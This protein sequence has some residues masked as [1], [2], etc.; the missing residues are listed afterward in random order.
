MK[1]LI[2]IIIS[3]VVFIYYRYT[4]KINPEFEIIQTQLDKFRP[5]MF[6]EKQPIILT[7]KL[8]DPIQLTKSIFKYLYVF[9]TQFITKHT[10]RNQQVK[11]KYLIVC[12]Q[13]DTTIVTIYHPKGE[14]TKLDINLYQSQCII[15]PMAWK[16]NVSHDATCI[17][18]DDTFTILGKYLI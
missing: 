16:Y 7:D 1:I 8:V 12:S 13:S 17:G 9:K 2:Y 10:E 6:F 4:L 11:F 3:L 14:E 15:I 5:S 18:M